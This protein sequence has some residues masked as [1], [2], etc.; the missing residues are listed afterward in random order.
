MAIALGTYSAAQTNTLL[1]A[2]Q[3][4]RTIRVVKLVFTAWGPTR[5]TL[6][7]DP[8]GA[9][10]S[11]LTP[12]LLTCGEPLVLRLGRR[13]ALSAGRGLGLGITTAFQVTPTTHSVML[14]YELVA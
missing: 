4:D 12:A 3:A 5:L 9:G 13:R 7:A 1:V 10:Q 14:W 6:I 2:A 11:E 8:G